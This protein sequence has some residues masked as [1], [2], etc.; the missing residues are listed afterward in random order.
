MTTTQN[1]TPNTLTVRATLSTSWRTKRPIA[2]SLT[3]ATVRDSFETIKTAIGAQRQERY[4]RCSFN[5]MPKNA[6]RAAT[7]LA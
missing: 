1:G 5:Y 4:T 7:S 2:A 3:L 6:K